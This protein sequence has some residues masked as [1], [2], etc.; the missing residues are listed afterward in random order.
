MRSWLR[1]TRLKQVLREND[2]VCRWGGEEFVMLVPAK[3]IEMGR[4]IAERARR[5]VEALEINTQDASLTVTASFGVAFGITSDES[6]ADLLAKADKV[7][8]EAKKTGRN[9]VRLYLA[10]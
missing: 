4:S 5:N 10:A 1:R 7:L 8:Y 9:Q 3:S 2:T 6:L